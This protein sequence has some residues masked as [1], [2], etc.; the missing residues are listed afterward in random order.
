MHERR[1]VHTICGL[2]CQHMH[3]VLPTNCQ[4]LLTTGFLKKAAN[5]L[6]ITCL[7]LEVA[8]VI[9]NASFQRRI[10]WFHV[11]K[12]LSLNF[13]SIMHINKVIL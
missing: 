12:F 13:V 5:R 9:F 4:Q 6:E 2:Y 11:S 3:M 7:H 8:F 1:F 10:Q